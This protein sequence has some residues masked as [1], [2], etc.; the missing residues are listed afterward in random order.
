MNVY[1]PHCHRPNYR[2]H[3]T[4]TGEEF[5]TDQCDYCRMAFWRD[6]YG[7][8]KRNMTPSSQGKGDEHG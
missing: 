6:R 8:V 3:T 7:Q 4:D 2:A 1:C 5:R